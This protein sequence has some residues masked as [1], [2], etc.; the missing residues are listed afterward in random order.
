MTRSLT[1]V[2]AA[3]GIKVNVIA[4]GAFTRMASRGAGCSSKRVNA[5]HSGSAFERA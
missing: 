2:G 5:R 4:P 1:A 3:H